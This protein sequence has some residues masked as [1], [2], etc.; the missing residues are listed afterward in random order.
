MCRNRPFA[1]WDTLP[2]LLQRRSWYEQPT[3]RR[4]P[5][6]ALPVWISQCLSRRNYIQFFNWVCFARYTRILFAACMHRLVDHA[7][8]WK[9]PRSSLAWGQGFYGCTQCGSPCFPTN[10]KKNATTGEQDFPTDGASHFR[11]RK[12]WCC[13]LQRLASC[14]GLYYSHFYSSQLHPDGQVAG[15]SVLVDVHYSTLS[16]FHW[17]LRLNGRIFEHAWVRVPT[18]AWTAALKLTCSNMFEPINIIPT[19]WINVKHV[20]L[21]LYP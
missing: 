17:H 8:P 19:S 14:S 4:R 6:L 9:F 3:V 5:S 2:Q 18:P 12:N 20:S 11:R 10:F 7:S 1:S 21:K 15:R 16:S 13:D